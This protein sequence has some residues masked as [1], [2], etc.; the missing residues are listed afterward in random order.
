MTIPNTLVHIHNQHIPKYMAGTFNRTTRRRALVN[1]EMRKSAS[2]YVNEHPNRH[3][4]VARIM[5]A[6]REPR[7]VFPSTQEDERSE[8]EARGPYLSRVGYLG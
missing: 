8:E 4:S 7:T 6:L 3:Q 5:S 2:S 1:S